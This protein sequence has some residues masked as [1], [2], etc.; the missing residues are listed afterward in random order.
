M[1]NCMAMCRFDVFGNGMREEETCG[2]SVRNSLGTIEK[3]SQSKIKDCPQGKGVAAV[4][5]FLSQQYNSTIA[6]EREKDASTTIKIS[7]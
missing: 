2:L 6:L 4:V 1:M 7:K 3:C 5:L